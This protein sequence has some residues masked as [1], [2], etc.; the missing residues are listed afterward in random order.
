MLAGDSDYGKGAEDVGEHGAAGCAGSAKGRFPHGGGTVSVESGGFIQ[1]VFSF[2]TFPTWE[3]TL[4]D[5][6]RYS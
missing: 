1:Q 3:I 2:G 5:V 4:R 6:F